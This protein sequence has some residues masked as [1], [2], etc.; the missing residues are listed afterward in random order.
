MRAA[1]R[2]TS[3]MNDPGPPP[4]TPNRSRRPSFAMALFMD[5]DSLPVQHARIE[6]TIDIAAGEDQGHALAGHALALLEQ[7]GE[8]PGA[9]AL[10][11]IVG[12]GEVVAHG[13]LDR[14]FAPGHDPVG[15]LEDE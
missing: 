7:G 8:R 9:G 12:V 15:A 1:V 5:M 13:R 2:W 11:E 3:P 10:D 4:I 6:G 14:V